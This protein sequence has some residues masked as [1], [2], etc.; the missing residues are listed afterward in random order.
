MP[1]PST[2]TSTFAG[3]DFPITV[4]ETFHNRLSIDDDHVT[5]ARLT[6]SVRP[7]LS[8]QALADAIGGHSAH[9]QARDGSADRQKADKNASPCMLLRPLSGDDAAERETEEASADEPGG[10]QTEYGYGFT[11]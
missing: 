3:I 4:T 6:G 11:P 8:G 9:D 7:K 5:Q 10:E 2:A 1:A